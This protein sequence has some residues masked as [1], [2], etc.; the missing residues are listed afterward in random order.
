MIR[1]YFKIAFRML[2]KDHFYS[3]I[4]ILGLSVSMSFCIL[5]GMYLKSEWTYDQHI[6]KAHNVYRL[7]FDQYTDLGAYATT[8]LP[9][10]P[11]LQADFPGCGWE[12][13]N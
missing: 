11:A 4:S 5:M 2:W 7:V 8:P 13:V 10:G 9:I 3:F 12:D 6:D 1:N